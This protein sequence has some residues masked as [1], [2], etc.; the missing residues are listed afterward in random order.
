[1][2]VRQAAL[3]LQKSGV[4]IMSIGRGRMDFT[5]IYALASFPKMKNAFMLYYSMDKAFTRIAYTVEAFLRG[6]V[7]NFVFVLYMVAN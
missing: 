4:Q 7:G 1:M 2:K 3:K 6:T 5:E